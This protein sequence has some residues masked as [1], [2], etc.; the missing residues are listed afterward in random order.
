MGDCFFLRLPGH[1]ERREGEKAREEA[2]G[3]RD[4]TGLRGTGV[5]A[6]AFPYLSLFFLLHP[7]LCVCETVDSGGQGDVMT[8]TFW[9]E[10]FSFSLPPSLSCVYTFLLPE[11]LFP[12]QFCLPAHT[13]LS[14]I[15]CIVL[16]ALPVL[17]CLY[18]FSPSALCLL[19]FYRD[20]STI[21]LHIC[22]HKHLYPHLPTCP[23]HSLPDGSFFLLS[24]TPLPFSLHSGPSPCCA[25]FAFAL[26]LLSS[27]LFLS[28]VALLPF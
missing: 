19:C 15:F 12:A 17:S 5:L 22:T 21:L 3:G 7:S 25:G 11:I 2:G 4:G 1:F 28:G 24:S 6:S 27:L 14:P 8:W 20:F 10:L 13:C 26:P 9:F 16:Y 18:S 23:S